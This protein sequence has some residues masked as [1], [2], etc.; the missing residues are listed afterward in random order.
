MIVPLRFQPLLL[1]AFIVSTLPR[2]ECAPAATPPVAPAAPSS[3][4]AEDDEIE[5]KPALDKPRSDPAAD[6]F[7]E[8]IRLFRSNQAG[9][10]TAGRAALREAADLEFTHA[11]VFLGECLISGSNGFARNAT[12]GASYYRLAAER[13]N[14][15]GQAALGRCYL[16]GIGVAKDQDKAAQW[17]EAA[18]APTADFSRP[19]PPANFFAGGA[20]T[21][22]SE[23][24]GEIEVDPVASTQAGAH[25]LLGVIK[26]RKKDLPA[27]Q[28][29]YV[30]AATAGPAGR[31]GIQQAAFQA[32][33]NYAFGQG[34]PRDM[35]KANDMLDRSKKLTRRMAAGAV[36]QYVKLKMVDDFAAADIEEEASAAGESAYTEIQYQIAQTFGNPKAKEYN[37]SEAVKWYELAAENGKPWA[38]LSL[39]FIYA[40]GD[41]GKPDPA[42]AFV[43]FEKAGGGDKP[44]H[45]L[46]TAN[47]GI[48][49][50]NGFGTAK[51]PEKAAAIFK[52]HRDEDFICHLGSIGQCPEKVIT[53]EE[54]LALN[55]EWAEKKNDPK[56]Q[57]FL[58]L[59]YWEG[60]G[61][62]ADFERATKLLKKAAKAGSGDAYCKLGLNCQRYPIVEGILRADEGT[63]RAMDYFQKGLD[64]GNAECAAHL[65]FLI[66]RTLGN[67]KG[68]EQAIALYERCLKMDPKNGMALNNLAVRLEA[69][70]REAAGN[71]QPVDAAAQAAMLRYYQEADQLESPQAAYNLGTLHRDGV[72]LEK[73]L[74]AA[75][76]CLET[77][78]ERGHTASRLILGQMHENGEG[79]PV[80]Y[81][82]AAY[83]YRLAALDGN[84]E[85]LRRLIVLYLSG[86]GVS[87]DLDRATF[88]LMR[89]ARSGQ[90]EALVAI[91]DIALQKGEF[92]QAVELFKRLE[93]NDLSSTITGYAQERL[94][95]CYEFGWGVKA[96]P[97]RARSYLEKAA[98]LNNADALYRTAVQTLA[99]GKT[100]E[101]LALFE[102]A[103]P[104][105]A[106]ASLALGKMCFFGTNVAQDRTKAWVHLRR[107]A[108][109]ADAEALYFLAAATYTNVPGAP[110]LDE[111]IRFAEQAETGGHP[112]AT[113]LR[114][115]LEKRRQAGPA[116]AE[117][118]TGGRPS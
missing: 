70:L 33:M 74:A 3:S 111:A 94:S 14:G 25:L 46:G 69:R 105:S 57:Y 100:A 21:A 82:E 48:C 22:A 36:H 97:G 108:S 35:A 118:A 116:P 12:K 42:K 66:Y 31:A 67:A 63:A 10:L 92:K 61:V 110:S 79:V 80:T 56:A 81:S 106:P 62:K 71:H 18:V 39:A 8:A 51:D 49:Y 104:Q 47:L 87:Q 99:E 7:W 43:W 68:T 101:A 1:L 64:L 90:V 55:R 23:V 103:A 77:A 27:A 65:A 17:L 93:K 20:P 73:D 40:H 37:L 95:R 117:D 52:Q 19:T 53:Y 2:T 113:A 13:G 109:L 29:H 96:N 38:M 28:A 15:Y 91:G 88:W 84:T 54:V 85:A 9:D 24:A 6:K 59:R 26:E 78:A 41:L 32:A 45:I 16:A 83:H 107:A 11:Q 112:K 30:A 102:R 60:T 89:L 75:Y 86:K 50:Q 44:K 4:E 5:E 76:R 98:K 72:L 114:E 34:A 115:K 58:A